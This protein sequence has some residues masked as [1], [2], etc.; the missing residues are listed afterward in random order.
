LFS[1]EHIYICSYVDCSCGSATDWH[2]SG[3]LYSACSDAADQLH[4]VA[5]SDAALL[6]ATQRSAVV[7]LA[8][9]VIARC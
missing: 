2:R 8:R 6:N 9:L 3:V 7:N 4:D 5:S 1:F